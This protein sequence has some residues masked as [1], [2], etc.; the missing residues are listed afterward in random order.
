VNTQHIPKMD[1]YDD[2]LF[3]VLKSLCYN[4]RK[5]C[6]DDEQ[7]SIVLGKDYVI[8]FQERK[9]DTYL[10]IRRNLRNNRGRIRK[11]GADYLAYVLSDYIVDMY[12]VLLEKLG[13]EIEALEEEITREP[14]QDSVRR[15]QK[16]KKHVMYIR[17]IIWP[18]RDVVS[19][20]TR[21]DSPL[22]SKNINIY[23]GDLH[24][25]VMEAIN[26][27]EAFRETLSS[28]VEIYM[29]SISNKTNEIMKVLA[30][31]STV[32]MPMTFITGIYGMNFIHMP[33]ISSEYGYYF[34]LAAMA[35][36]GTTML[37]YY[38]IRKWI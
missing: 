24:D 12:F 18:M 8:T 17:K 36:V 22:I 10:E 3:I 4:K 9:P 33:E 6:L 5:K 1:D 34:A 7:I 20:L 30:V 29:Y 11:M 21:R 32:F 35:I 28:M 2:H 19:K 23:L 16:L 26:T 31:F 25:H 27:V 13:D 15:I 14:S 37:T 38:K